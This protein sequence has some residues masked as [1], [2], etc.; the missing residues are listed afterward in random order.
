MTD[1]AD[2]AIWDRGQWTGGQ[3]I[4]YRPPTRISDY[5]FMSARLV[6]WS[7]LSA[8]SEMLRRK[9]E[10]SAIL[11][12]I[13][14]YP[15]K[16]KLLLAFGDAS[17]CRATVFRWFKEFF[18][19]HNSLQDKEPAERQWSA[20]IPDNVPAIRKMLMDDNRCTYK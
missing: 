2:L 12:K 5:L 20:V 15:L 14:K 6:G 10:R 8:D 9:L 11:D 13:T 3:V 19:C 17:P 16:E 1:G 18:S 4:Y 7:L